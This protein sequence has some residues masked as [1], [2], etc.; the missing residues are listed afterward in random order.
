M[1]IVRAFEHG[2]AGI[3]AA[4]PDVKLNLDRDPAISDGLVL[5]VSYPAPTDDPAGRDVWCEAEQTDWTS[6]RSISFQVKPGAA[7]KLSVSFFDR[8]RVAYTTWVELQGGLWQPVR[9]AFENLRPNPYF[10]P[11][12]ANTG[13]SIDVSEVRGV[14]FAPHDAGSGQLALSRFVVVP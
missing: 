7:L 14:A 5:R 3:A 2:L 11:P 12:E 13:T 6:G 10:Q 1:I 8:N 4:N 9:L